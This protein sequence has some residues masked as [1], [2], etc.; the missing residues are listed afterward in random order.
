[1]S[2]RLKRHLLEVGAVTTVFAA[3][4]AALLYWSHPREHDH[5]VFGEETR[6]PVPMSCHRSRRVRRRL[7]RTLG[8]LTTPDKAPSL[9][10]HSHVHSTTPTR[11]LS[12]R[13]A[14]TRTPEPRIAHC[15]PSLQPSQHFR[16]ARRC[17]S[18]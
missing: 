6:P 17:S 11:S 13:T 16:A 15:E 5:D 3:F 14:M 12:P 7:R 1:M 9:S 10:R 2:P 4:V 18:G 8:R